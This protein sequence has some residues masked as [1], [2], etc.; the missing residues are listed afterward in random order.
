MKCKISQLEVNGFNRQLN[1]AHVAKLV[2]SIGTLGLLEPLVV[3][4]SFPDMLKDN[5]DLL[6]V[7][8]RHRLEAI[9]ELVKAK[10]WEGDE[11]DVMPRPFAS[12]DK[13]M[14]A[15]AAENLLR[16][17]TFPWEDAELMQKIFK[18]DNPP[19]VKEV[20]AA[21]GVKEDWVIRR[22]RLVNLDSKV[23]KKW[24]KHPEIPVD[25]MEQIAL[26]PQDD[27]FALTDED[28]ES[29]WDPDAILS[30]MR[31]NAGDLSKAPW[32]LK[33][34]GPVGCFVPNCTV[35]RYNTAN[36]KELFTAAELKEVGKQTCTNKECFDLK[37]EAWLKEKTEAFLKANA[38]GSLLST[39]YGAKAGIFGC[40]KWAKVKA[41]VPGA[42]PG[43]LVDGEDVGQEITFKLVTAKEIKEQAAMERGEVVPVKD[44]KA[45]AEDRKQMLQNKRDTHMV[46][47]FMKLLSVGK[48]ESLPVTPP[49]VVF[50][51][52][53]FG[54]MTSERYAAG[55]DFTKD[56]EPGLELK[57]WTNVIPVLKQRW[58]I[59]NMK[60]DCPRIVP[61][62]R[63]FAKLIGFDLKPLDT[64]A[65][66]ANP[67][68]K[69]MK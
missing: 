19:T 36:G 31:M 56:Y 69:S 2:Q 17:D 15:C 34:F 57:L 27:Q 43:L 53:Y 60:Q 40:D 11:V 67:K 58:N 45:K 39:F 63:A 13:L 42:L 33:I 25:T 28:G 21:L 38:T 46:E 12:K 20:A 29:M 30:R 41:S 16:K 1:K 54:T 47:A 32:D 52:S 37:W 3:T 35:C 68:P 49:V 14:Q 10:K 9:K 24:A 64:A 6:L 8:G 26:L 66:N 50:M 48:A 22:R 59:H 7:A 55:K 62:V 5:H 44:D 61:E 23:L 65:E 4:A 18:V 51:A